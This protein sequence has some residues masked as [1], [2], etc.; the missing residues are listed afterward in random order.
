MDGFPALVPS[1]RR[2][3]C[4]TAPLLGIAL[5]ILCVGMG[6]GDF[7]LFGDDS[8]NQAPVAVAS[9][10]KETPLACQ[11]DTVNLD[12]TESSDP[13]E[14][15]LTYQWEITSRP[16]GSTAAL[17]NAT[18]SQ[19]SFQP[20]EAGSYT[21]DLTVTDAGGLS[22]SASVSVVAGSDPVADAGAD[23]QVSLGATVSL[24][25]SESV[26]PEEG[27]ETGGLSFL[28]SLEDPEGGQI[29]LGTDVQAT[30]TAAIEGTY[31]ATLTVETDSASDSDV[32]EIT[33]AGAT[34]ESLEIGPYVLT[35]EGVTDTIFFG[36]VA[37]VFPPGTE[38]D[39]TVDM[40]SPDQVPVS[41]TVSLNHPGGSFG[42]AVIEI[43]RQN[44]EDNFYTLTGTV[45][46]TG[47]VSGVQCRIEAD[48]SGEVTPETTTTVGVTLTISNAE[49]TGNPLCSLA[50]TEGTVQLTLSGELQQAE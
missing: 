19:A 15:S 21:I 8:G 48:C 25:G 45:S 1:R 11:K 41:R 28:W 16:V 6:C 47:S 17:Q 36:Y 49:V 2:F 14:D 50:N 22:D 12:G 37:S 18:A 32:A 40:P 10:D 46:G 42:Q 39:G 44:P 4:R 27:C 38:L 5:L 33:V 23:R 20:D 30:F 9:A 29:E 24:D 43:A 13:D 3:S 7:T 34:L 35:V 31:T 26:N